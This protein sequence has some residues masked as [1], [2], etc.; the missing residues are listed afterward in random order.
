MRPG[1]PTG[2]SFFEGIEPNDAAARR[3]PH[4]QTAAPAGLTGKVPYPGAEAVGYRLLEWSPCAPLPCPQR[5]WL[6]GIDIRRARWPGLD[7]R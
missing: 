2:T 3:D 1:M 5:A 4:R 7:Q 6:V